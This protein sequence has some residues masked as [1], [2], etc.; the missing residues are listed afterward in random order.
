GTCGPDT[1]GMAVRVDDRTF[2]QLNM[3]AD[4]NGNCFSP[5]NVD[6][7][8][9]VCADPGTEQTGGWANDG[10]TTAPLCWSRLEVIL[11]NGPTSGT[12]MVTVNWKGTT[13]LNQYVITNYANHRGRLVLMGRTGGNNQ[14]AH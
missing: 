14:N 9:R 11:T 4:R 10:G 7:D 12:K 8:T 1:E 5:T 13:L 2:L 3:Q 6:C